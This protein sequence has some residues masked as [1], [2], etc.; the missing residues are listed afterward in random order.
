[1]R[2]SNEGFKFSTTKRIPDLAR[3]N[4]DEIMELDSQKEK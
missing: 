2:G 3:H 4:N 1:M